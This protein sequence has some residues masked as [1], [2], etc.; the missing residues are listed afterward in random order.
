MFRKF[1]A[2]E[3]LNPKITLYSFRHTCITEL[4]RSGLDLRTVQDIAGHSDM[5]KCFINSTGLAVLMDLLL[6]IKD[7]S[8][9]C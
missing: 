5:R 6:P 3:D 8:I 4:L 9:D 7:T 2:A 1:V